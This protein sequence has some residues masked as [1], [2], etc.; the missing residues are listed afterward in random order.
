MEVVEQAPALVAPELWNSGAVIIIVGLL[1]WAVRLLR[2][3]LTY[4]DM[5]YAVRQ[6][7]VSGLVIVLIGL[8]ERIL[9]DLVVPCCRHRPYSF[10]ILDQGNEDAHLEVY[11][12][13][14]SL[15]IS[16]SLDS[17]VRALQHASMWH[18]QQL[19]RTKLEETA[20]EMPR[21]RVPFDILVPSLRVDRWLDDMKRPKMNLTVRVT[22]AQKCAV[23]VLWNVRVDAIELSN[24]SPY[25][26]ATD[27][28]ASRKTGLSRLSSSVY[29][30]LGMARHIR[31][32]RGLPWP[33]SPVQRLDRR[34]RLDDEKEEEFKVDGDSATLALSW[35]GSKAFTS[36]STIQRCA[37]LS[38]LYCSTTNLKWLCS[39]RTTDLI[40][41]ASTSTRPI[42]Q[43]A[44][45]SAIIT[46][47]PH[48]L[49]MRLDATTMAIRYELLGSEQRRLHRWSH[50]TVLWSLLARHRS[51]RTR[52]R[53]QHA[54]LR[55][56]RP[57]TQRRLC[58]SASP[59]TFYR[60]RPACQ[61]S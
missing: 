47:R 30:R 40:K 28:T 45:F 18:F 49:L 20:T 61:L 21:I 14:L 60:R 48:R 4:V 9:I 59:S 56:A 26:D 51:S 42:Y 32:S 8:S 38:I 29:R 39:C 43:S 17:S 5:R 55:M 15:L 11:P 35:L 50:A 53:K 36:H 12:T 23:Q 3:L 13:F 46:R 22:S 58:V 24:R 37:L 54:R 52:K 1:G 6:D 44:L 41:V 2:L 10:E 7:A 34:H 57:L 19:L 31:G 25:G 27:G 33:L 16:L